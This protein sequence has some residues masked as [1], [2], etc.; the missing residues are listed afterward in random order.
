MKAQILREELEDKQI[1]I[2]ELESKQNLTK[3]QLKIQKEANDMLQKK[4]EH[5]YNNNIMI[6]KEGKD[7]EENQREEKN[8]KD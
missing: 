2:D 6:P 7:D 4:L 8:Q 5:I 1:L 3:D